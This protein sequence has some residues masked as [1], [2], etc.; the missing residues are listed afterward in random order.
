M[1]LKPKLRKVEFAW[2]PKR[3]FVWT[4]KG[5]VPIG[6]YWLWDVKLVRTNW[7]GWTAFADENDVERVVM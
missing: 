1:M 5:F 7:N 2:F 6:F 4:N 3:R